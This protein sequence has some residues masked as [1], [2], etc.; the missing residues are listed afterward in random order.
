MNKNIPAESGATR[1]S[2]VPGLGYPNGRSEVSPQPTGWQAS[3]VLANGSADQ[4]L[5]TLV[6]IS[7]NTTSAH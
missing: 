1:P 3:R 6:S 5:A 2:V 4:A 7:I